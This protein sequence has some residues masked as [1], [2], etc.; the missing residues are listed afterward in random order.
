MATYSTDA[1]LLKVAP[2]ASSWAIEN[3][4]DD[5]SA[6]WLFHQE[7]AYAEINAFL[8]GKTA[9]PVPSDSYASEAL[10]EI[11]A[12]M[13]AARLMKA[14]LSQFNNHEESMLTIQQYEGDAQRLLDKTY[15]PASASTPA[16]GT[17]FVGNGTLTVTVNDDYAFRSQWTV[18]CMDEAGTVFEIA[19][20]RTEAGGPWFYELGTDT[21][22]PS[23]ADFDSARANDMLKALTL[24]IATGGTAFSIGDFW[25]FTMF[26]SY[27]A[28]RKPGL[29]YISMVRV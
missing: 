9:V 25:T 26:P 21:Q 6:T 17:G 29:G 2:L 14:N 27:R 5:P 15:F 22:W 13:V 19:T 28:N 3:V 12:R 1:D 8:R 10:S 11:E 20:D 18:K 16:S 24:T 4:G 23:N 7:Q